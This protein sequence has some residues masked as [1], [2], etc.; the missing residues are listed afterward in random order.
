MGTKKRWS[1]ARRLK[2]FLL[3][4]AFVF[5]AVRFSLGD[6]GIL[7]L[8]RLHSKID[9]TE[10]EITKI[11]VRAVDLNWETNKL[12]SDSL[13]LLLF[14]AEHCGYAWPNRT[15][16]QFLPPRADRDYSATTQR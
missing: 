1:W 12:R 13:F 4:S 3:L 10:R 11:K 7:R 16:I 5:I 15:I 14:A 9:L 2:Q 8:T 6:S